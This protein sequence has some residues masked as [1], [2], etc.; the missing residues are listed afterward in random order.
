MAS[1]TSDTRPIVAFTTATSPTNLSS[2]APEQVTSLI[3][4][5]IVPVDRTMSTQSDRRCSS[6]SPRRSTA[7][8]TF[9]T[10]RS[11]SASPKDPASD[12]ATTPTTVKARSSR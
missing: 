12:A 6:Q 9:F 7:S 11:S 10:P 2:S 5:V 8:P 4:R 1:K 3:A